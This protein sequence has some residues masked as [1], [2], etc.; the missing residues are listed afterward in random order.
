[1]VLLSYEEDE[2]ITNRYII[3]NRHMGSAEKYRVFINSLFE[4]V[5]KGLSKG[6]TCKWKPTGRVGI[7]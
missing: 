5:T 6:E 7:R 1:M 3:V 4:R 2:K